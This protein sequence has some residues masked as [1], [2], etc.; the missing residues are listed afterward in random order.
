[1][2]VA[3]YARKSRL[4][5]KGESIH[6][7]IDA[8]KNYI[9]QWGNI[10]EEVE[11]MVYKDEGFSGGNIDRPHFKQMLADAKCNKF[12]KLICYRL[13]RVSRNI[14]DFSNTY[15]LLNE[16]NIE[17]VS[18][19]EQF[20]TSTPI[21]RAMLN[22]AMVFAQLERETIAERI[23]D[24]MLALARTGRWLGGKTPTGYKSKQIGYSG[25]VNEKKMFI[26]EQDP[27]EI[28][29]IKIIFDKFLEIKS[30]RGVESYL[31][32]HDIL[33]PAGKRYTAS[34]L[35]DIL[36]NPVYA[37]ADQEVFNYFTLKESD[38][39]N[40][41]NEFDGQ[42][43]LMVYNRTDQ[44]KSKPVMKNMNEWIVSIGQHEPVIDGS[45][46]VSIQNTLSINTTKQFY[47]KEGMN[48]GILS[49]LIKC[50][51]CGATMKIKKG[52]V[53]ADGTQAFSY[54]CSNKDISRGTKC[55]VKNIIGQEVD[56]DVMEYLINLAEN[57]ADLDKQIHYTDNT[58]L[59]SNYNKSKYIEDKLF[60]NSSKINNLMG[61]MAQLDA[62]S[63]LLPIYLEQLKSLDKEKQ[64][65]T[66]ELNVL[67]DSSKQSK[68]HNLNLQLVKSA[69][70]ELRD[71]DKVLSIQQQR[72]LVRSVISN[73]TWDG[74]NLHIELF[75]Q[76]VM[77]NLAETTNL[78]SDS[79]CY[80]CKSAYIIN[81]SFKYKTAS[82]EIINNTFGCK[83]N[84]ARTNK[85]IGLKEFAKI[86]GVSYSTLN[87]WEKSETYPP[88]EYLK[89]ISDAL[90]IPLDSL[91][92]E[93]I[94]FIEKLPEQI[95]AIQKAF[96]IDYKELGAKVGINNTRTIREWCSG[97]HV[98]NTTIV[99]K[100]ME[101][102]KAAA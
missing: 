71:I 94:E 92:D 35:K 75:G 81:Q 43:G 97:K 89:V 13:D 72:S 19:K 34:T 12:N 40:I 4:S 20:D 26:L 42:H 15:E 31:T 5:D 88:L 7:Q 79:E 45:K 36:L 83:L 102:K 25:D 29:T 8:C 90:D 48:Y 69:I 70:R 51:C 85:N 63:T 95:T 50:K 28:E 44:S 53:M 21:G 96:N 101:L 56:V 11:F 59:T 33:T 47:N 80:S 3:I 38:I 37:S 23:K 67:N 93:Y 24:N 60:K 17:F 6:N 58:V 61:Q 16:H 91:K 49:S 65:L 1:M 66:A 62:T 54:V 2:K 52:K 87:R 99:K 74:E 64:E 68:M 27:E 84:I 41:Q 76:N 73:I 77:S 39:C 78:C 55:S 46:W 100:L 22:I 82:K 30:L 86:L 9:I 32:I 18:V 14:A 57:E 98:P 10:S